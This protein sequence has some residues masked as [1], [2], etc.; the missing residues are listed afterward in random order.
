MPR[1]PNQS[2]AFFLAFERC[3]ERRRLP[4]GTFQMLV[5]PATVCLAFSIELGLKSLAVA[6]GASPWGHALAKLFG[7]LTP[8]AQEMLVKDVGLTR[9]QFDAALAAASNTFEDWR[10]VHEPQPTNP[11]AE[12]AFLEALGRAVQKALPASP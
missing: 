7:T 11:H 1:P 12:I 10:Y 6:E 9:A 8:T 3:M 2:R 4:G 5:V